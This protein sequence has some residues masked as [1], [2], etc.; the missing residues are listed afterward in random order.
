MRERGKEGLK[1]AARECFRGW[2][3]KER[4]IASSD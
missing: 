4:A 3:F 2:R 1:D